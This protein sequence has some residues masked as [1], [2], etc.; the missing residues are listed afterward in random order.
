LRC[1]Q[2]AIEQPS[3]RSDQGKN[4]GGAPSTPVPTGIGNCAD[5]NQGAKPP[6]WDDNQDVGLFEGGGTRQTGIFRP[7]VN[8]RMSS[9]APP[10][11]P[12]CYTSFKRSYDS[13]TGHHFRNC[14]AGDFNGDGR[15]DVL[16]HAGNAIQIFRS[17]GS[18]LDHAFSAVE[19]VPGSWQ[20]QPNDQ[21][22]IGDFNGDGRDEVVVF[23][24]GDWAIPYLGLL[25]DD[26]HNGLRLIARYDGDIPGWGG[27]AEHDK[28]YV[29]DFSGDGKKDLFV[30]NGED[31]SMT[32][33]AMLRS[34]SSP[35]RRTA[36]SVPSSP[37]A[38]RAWCARHGRRTGG[39]SPLG[40]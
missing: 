26:G 27:L 8:C 7:V 1:S 3:V 12:V 19:R 31:W 32:Y 11:C 13:W 21:F 36:H 35:E 24:G 34:T 39:G 4:S 25:A 38:A 40:P 17:N 6:T 20:F 22:Y 16:I 29:A 14:Y 2:S 30:F 37:K 9:N 23:N 33:V 10:Y 15:S 5:Y 18:Q 28:F